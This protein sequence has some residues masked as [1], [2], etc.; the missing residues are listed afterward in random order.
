MSTDVI[1][2]DDYVWGSYGLTGVARVYGWD[3]EVNGWFWDD[4]QTGEALLTSEIK[5]VLSLDGNTQT[6][7][8]NRYNAPSSFSA[9]FGDLILTR[10]G[11]WSLFPKSYYSDPGHVSYYYTSHTLVGEYKL[12][13]GGG[14]MPATKT[15]TIDK[16]WRDNG[17][18]DKTGKGIYTPIGGSGG[19]RFFGFQLY[20]DTIKASD[21][22]YEWTQQPRGLNYNNKSIYKV[23]VDPDGFDKTSCWYDEH[24]WVISGAPGF[25][26]VKNYG[27]WRGGLDT[28]GTYTL[29]YTTPK[30]VTSHYDP[31]KTYV[32]PPKIWLTTVVTPPV[33][34]DVPNFSWAGGTLISTPTTP[35]QTTLIDPSVK[36]FKPP[37]AEPCPGWKLVALYSSDGATDPGP[38]I[39][40]SW[41][42]KNVVVQAVF[43]PKRDTITLEFDRYDKR[44]RTTEN[45]LVTQNAVWLGV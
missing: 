17:W 25:K 8:F 24:N 20:K 4:L 13:N 11:G 14:G 5:L 15:M 9:V 41:L 36:G 44:V 21:W 30:D 3:P 32:D 42:S 23:A 37:E 45:M 28:P 40:L 26:D 19:N 7:S 39:P 29:Q 2:L 27:W 12:Q 35:V 10:Q 18:I 1:L 43:A 38:A 31:E 33:D 6:V 34:P 22:S 16:S